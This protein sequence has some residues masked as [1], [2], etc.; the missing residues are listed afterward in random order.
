M[1]YLNLTLNTN[2]L[3]NKE[4]KLKYLGDAL[5]ELPKSLHFL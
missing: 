4:V 2:G 5:K 3:G 1:Q